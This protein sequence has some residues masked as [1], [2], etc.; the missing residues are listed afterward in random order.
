MSQRILFV[1]LC[2]IF[3]DVRAEVVITPTEVYSQVLLIERE[4]ELVKRHFDYAKQPVPVTK[5]DANI[6]TRHVWQKCYMLQ[7]KLVAFRRKHQLVGLTPVGVEP[8]KNMDTR[9]IW[10]QTQRILVEIRIIRMFLGISGQDGAVLSVDSKKTIEPVDMF[11]KLS[12]IEAEWDALTGADFDASYAFG[13]AMRLSEEVDIMLRYLNVFDD[14]VP[15]ENNP[16]A[17]PATTL[18][19]T[20]LV[21]EQLQR[22]QRLAG[23]DIA[24]LSIFRKSGQVSAYDVFNMTCMTLAELQTIKY[25]IGLKHVVTVPANHY[26]NKTPSD[27]QQLLGYITNKLALI[28]HL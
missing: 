1:L 17:T 28:Q 20:F 23:L 6:A 19:Q 11:N 26:E 8:S 14:A 27:V 5:V 18:T 21:L 25:Q 16:A 15:P 9:D 22:L 24:D 2:L 4:T 13:Q 7:K 12:Q 3:L 10:A